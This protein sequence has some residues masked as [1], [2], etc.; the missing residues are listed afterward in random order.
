MSWAK[1]INSVIPAK[2]GTHEHRPN[3][4]YRKP[5]FMGSG[6]RLRRPRNDKAAR[7]MTGRPPTSLILSDCL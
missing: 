3:R 5:V 7:Q 6:F 4:G 2:A 1:E